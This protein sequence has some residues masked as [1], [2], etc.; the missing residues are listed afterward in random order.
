M[1]RIRLFM[2]AITVLTGLGGLVLLPAATYAATPKSTVCQTLGSDSSCGSTPSGGIDINGIVTAIVNILSF[3][4]GVA[5]V[6]MII[7]A[8][9][10]LIT[11]NGDSSSIAS[12]RTAII[13]AIVGLAVVACSQ[14]IVYFVLS[15]VK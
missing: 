1:K 3:V 10:R 2:A 4:V 6:V 14:A 8:G 13:Y 12:A 15:K 5:A 9:F 7:I 11:A